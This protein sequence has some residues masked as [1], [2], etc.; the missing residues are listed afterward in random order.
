MNPIP[1]NL[2]TVIRDFESFARSH[3]VTIETDGSIDYGQ[4][5]AIPPIEVEEESLRKLVPTV[6]PEG[7]VINHRE[8]KNV[9]RVDSLY[10]IKPGVVIVNAAGT[11]KLPAYAINRAGDY[12]TGLDGAS[13]RFVNRNGSTNDSWMG[14]PALDQPLS[15][16]LSVGGDIAKNYGRN[17]AVLYDLHQILTGQKE[18]RILLR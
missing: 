10:T 9:C 18:G 2:V 5:R 11:S 1:E 13:V 14:K 15:T 12:V 7:I 8:W 3:G 16:V 17:V 6:F 4:G